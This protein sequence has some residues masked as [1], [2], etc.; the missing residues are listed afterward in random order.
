LED[1]NIK[2]GLFFGIIAGFLIGLQPIVIVSRPAVIDPYI[3]ATMTFI[4]VSLI[5]FPLVLIERKK[6]RKKYENGQ[7]TSEDS[8][9]L[10][11]GWKTNKKF[12]IY[13]GV[14][15]GC[16]RIFFFLGFQLAGAINGSLV[17]KMRIVLALGFGYL[18]LRERITKKQIL[19]STVLLFGLFFAITQGTLNLMEFNIEILWGVL[20]LFTIG[21]FWTIAH[22]QTKPMIDK[23][24]ATPISIVFSRS[25]IGALIL[26]STYFLFFPLENVK[27]FYDPINIYYFLAIGVVQGLG[28]LCWYKTI[29]YLE[30]SKAT[31]IVAPTPIITALFA[32]FFLGELFTIYHLIGNLII[33]VSI[34]MIVR[35][36]HDMEL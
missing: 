4:V 16:G 3:F 17:Q 9:S 34:T 15:F 24:E 10:L 35:E 27:I 36:K 14:V 6:I 2:K 18:I 32:Y 20:I 21:I 33:I 30:F 19:F 29:S 23:K 11:H 13:L 1:N 5:F 28:L 26:M 25:I 12:L 31:I 7:L 8:N 22:I